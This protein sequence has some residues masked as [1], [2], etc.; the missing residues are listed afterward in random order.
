MPAH[1]VDVLIYRPKREPECARLPMLTQVEANMGRKPER[2]SAGAGYWSE[3]NVVAESV[4]GIGL[5]IARGASNME[6]P[7][8]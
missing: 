3:S 5:P 6:I 8:R 1:S 7:S 2:A 4:A